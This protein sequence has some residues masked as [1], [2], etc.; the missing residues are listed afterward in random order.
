MK[1]NLLIKIEARKMLQWFNCYAIVEK[2]RKQQSNCMTLHELRI[3]KVSINLKKIIKTIFF[4]SFKNHQDYVLKE[5][6]LA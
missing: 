4:N 5:H 3:A 1:I 2:N 6:I